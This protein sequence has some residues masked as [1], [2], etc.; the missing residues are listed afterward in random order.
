[1]ASARLTNP[2]LRFHELARQTV[3]PKRKPGTFLKENLRRA[4]KAP[5]QIKAFSPSILPFEPP[6]PGN[7]YHEQRTFAWKQRRMWT[8]N[9]RDHALPVRIF[10]GDQSLRERMMLTAPMKLRIEDVDAIEKAGGLE[11]FL[12][13]TRS[14]ELSEHGKLLRHNLF[15]ELNRMR[16]TGLWYAGPSSKHYDCHHRRWVIDSHPAYHSTEVSVPCR[17]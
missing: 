12:I 17:T 11:A 15:Q 5:D 4:P 8:P 10:G 14:H 2:Y 13:H 1:M 16:E 6:K 3:K 9:Y 7:E